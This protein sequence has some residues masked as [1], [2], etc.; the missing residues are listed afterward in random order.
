MNGDGALTAIRREDFLSFRSF[1]VEK[2]DLEDRSSNT[3][4]KDFDKLTNVLHTVIDAMGIDFTPPIPKRNWR[5][6]KVEAVTG[7]PRAL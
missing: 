6:P 1:W 3:A 2:I 5:L 4:N 7:M